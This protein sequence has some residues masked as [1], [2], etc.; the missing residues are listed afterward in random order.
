MG[1]KHTRNAE[2]LNKWLRRGLTD[3]VVG[4]SSEHNSTHWDKI[5]GF[6]FALTSQGR[7]NQDPEGATLIQIIHAC[8]DAYAHMNTHTHTQAHTHTH[9]ETQ[10]YP[11]TDI[12][13]PSY[14]HAHA[15]THAHTHTHTHDDKNTH[16]WQEALLSLR[17]KCNL[18]FT[19]R[20]CSTISNWSK[21]W[22]VCFTPLN[23][24]S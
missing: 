16:H 13:T 23:D 17:L 11:Q 10:M 8:S 2:R 7:W 1:Y 21:G 15:S 6:R 24:T 9:T 20:W 18:D 22:R 5:H 14:S 19:T 12:H 3:S 4:G